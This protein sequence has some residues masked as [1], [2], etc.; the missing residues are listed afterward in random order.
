MELTSNNYDLKLIVTAENG[1]TREY[2]I[3]ITRKDEVITQEL[4]EIFDTLKY[5]YTDKYL[6]GF[7]LGTDVS[8]IINDLK[9]SASNLN[10]EYFDKDMKTKTSGIIASGDN[11]K[12]TYNGEAFSYKVII[13]GD[14]NGDGKIVATDY[15]LI[16]N[17]IMDVKKLTD[18]EQLCADTNKDGKVLATDYVAIK[19]HIM[20]VKPIVQ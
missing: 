10:V 16:K 11:I 3:N 1:D 13:Y 7:V 5:K 4:T 14:V 2:I 20:D 6:S 8:K 18:F 15:V 9:N 12:I 17:H 19:N